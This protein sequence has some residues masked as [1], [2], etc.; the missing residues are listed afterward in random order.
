MTGQKKH[1]L[2]IQVTA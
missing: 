2:Y 1:D